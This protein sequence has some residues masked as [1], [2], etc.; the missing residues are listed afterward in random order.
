[1]W[2]EKFSGDLWGWKAPDDAFHSVTSSAS[3]LREHN[4]QS[5]SA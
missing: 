5:D 2:M 1:V 3:D 4:I